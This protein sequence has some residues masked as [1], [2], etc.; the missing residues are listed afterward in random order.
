M[1]WTELLQSEAEEAYR[2]TEG[3]MDHVDADKLDW[4][5][6]PGEWMPT[7]E[8]LVHLTNACGWCCAH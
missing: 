2:A 5:P 1:N 6:E 4:K 8:L 7:R 3:L